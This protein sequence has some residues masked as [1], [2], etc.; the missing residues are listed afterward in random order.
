MKLAP[1]VR[2]VAML[3]MSSLTGYDRD[4]AERESWALAIASFMVVSLQRPNDSD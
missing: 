3:S 1:S 2:M 4:T